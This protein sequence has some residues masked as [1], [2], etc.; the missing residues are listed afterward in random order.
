[1]IHTHYVLSARTRREKMMWVVRPGKSG[2]F[3]EKTLKNKKIY[4]PWDGYKLD[5]STVNTI[6]DCRRIVKAEKGEI[7]KVSESN[8]A[9]QLFVF[10]RKMNKNDYVLIPSAYSKKYCLAKVVGDYCFNI[11]EEDNLYHS[12]DIKL[13]CKDIPSSIFPIDIKYSLGAFRTIFLVKQE[14]DVIKIISFWKK[15]NRQLILNK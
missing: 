13:L 9:G 8:W 1:M 2:A 14:E 5:L 6:Q 7:N 11:N 15:T 10:A 3:F 4:L 12:R